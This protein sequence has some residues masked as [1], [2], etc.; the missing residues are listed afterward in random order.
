MSKAVKIIKKGEWFY[1]RRTQTLW[2]WTKDQPLK[3]VNERGLD[4]V[5]Q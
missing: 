1:D 3:Y 5:K 4:R 2:K